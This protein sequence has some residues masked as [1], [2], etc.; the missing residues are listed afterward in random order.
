MKTIECKAPAKVNYRLDV[1][2]RRPDGYHDLRMIMQRID[3]CDDIR[4]SLSETPGVRVAC[5][6]EGVPDGPGNIAWRAADA[7]LKLSGRCTGIDISIVKNIPVAAGLGGGSS[8]CA[9]ALMGVNELLELHLTDEQLMEAGSKLGADVPFFI[10]KKTA[11]AEGIGDKLAA[12]EAAPAWLVIVNPNLAVSTA[13]VYQNLQLTA[14]K[15]E[16][17]IPRFYGSVSDIC[18]ILANDLEKVTIG[19]FPVINQIKQKLLQVG[20][21]GS[22]MSGSGSTVFGIFAEEAPARKAAEKLSRES[23]WFVAAVKTL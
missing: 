2:R 9:S 20:A 14:G 6:K 4:I 1:L 18:A 21:A 12:V 15:D 23:D 13:W 5:G 10:F 8:D 11:L 16:Y 22:L 17:I 3:L 7:L 19:R